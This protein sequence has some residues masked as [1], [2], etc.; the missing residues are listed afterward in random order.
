MGKYEFSDITHNAFGIQGDTASLGASIPWYSLNGSIGAIFSSLMPN[1][2]A[3][4]DVRLK[5]FSKG[6]VRTAVQATVGCAA[7]LVI[8]MAVE[9]L[10]GPK[11]AQYSTTIDKTLLFWKV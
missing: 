1:K 8:D 2:A 10:C 3:T 4:A 11:W 7:I 9:R 5:V 6:V